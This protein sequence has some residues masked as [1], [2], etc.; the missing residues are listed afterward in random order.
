MKN[1][2]ALQALLKTPGKKIVITTHHK[3]DADALG[4][5]LALYWYL[6]KKG[7]VPVVVS[8]TDYPSF[9]HWMNGQESVVIF[10][11]GK[12]KHSAK[13]IEEADVICCLDFSALHRINEVGDLVRKAKGIKILIDHH[14]EKEAFA[15]LEFCDTSAAATAELL[16]EVIT[17][18]GD[19]SYIDECIGACLYAG[20]MTDTGSFKYASTS[21]KT[22]RI[23][24]L[25]M[26]KGVDAAAIHRCIFDNNSEKRIKFLGYTLSEKL[27]VL[28]EYRT[29]YIALRHDDLKK[30]DSKTGDTEGLV[31]YALSIEGI[32]FAVVIIDRVETVKLSFRSVGDFSVN[33]FASKH[34]EG[35]GHKNAAGGK[36]DLGLEETV[37]KFRMLLP[38]YQDK[39]TSQY[40]SQKLLC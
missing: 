11:E 34:F 36:S 12:E 29:A 37:K 32:V 40:K 9:L 22:H 14:L 23:C 30:F 31:N 8:P 13:L 17:A 35:G 25:L 19:E 21:P 24:A 10:N 5:S 38:E 1:I 26:E 18:L 33:E 15:D 28:P 20:I 6:K 16:Y 27:T 39:I 3:P 7:H 2:D 4:S